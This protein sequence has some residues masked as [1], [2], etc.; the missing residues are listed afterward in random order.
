[1]S[2]AAM[3]TYITFLFCLFLGMT[4]LAN[5]PPY[6]NEEIM[7][8]TQNFEH[9]FSTLSKNYIEQS[10]YKNAL[11]RAVQLQEFCQI[12]R[13]ETTP[14]G[15]S[16][17]GLKDDA[18]F[19]FDILEL[20]D[21]WVGCVIQTNEEIQASID[22]IK[23]SSEHTLKEETITILKEMLQ[24]TS[25]FAKSVS[26]EKSDKENAMS[27]STLFALNNM[28]LSTYYRL[29][30][31]FGKHDLK[32][33]GLS[34]EEAITKL[35]KEAISQQEDAFLDNDL[36]SLQTKEFVNNAELKSEYALIIGSF[37]DCMRRNAM[38]PKL[39]C[40]SDLGSKFYKIYSRTKQGDSTLTT[41]PITAQDPH[42]LYAFRL[43]IDAI[44]FHLEACNRDYRNA[45]KQ[46]DMEANKHLQCFE[47]VARNSLNNIQEAKYIYGNN[48]A[49]SESALAYLSNHEYQTFFYNTG[50]MVAKAYAAT[51]IDE[52][53]KLVEDVYDFIGNEEKY[54]LTQKR[55]II[56]FNTHISSIPQEI[57]KC[58]EPLEKNETLGDIMQIHKIDPVCFDT[59][60]EKYLDDPFQ[61]KPA[62]WRIVNSDKSPLVVN[63]AQAALTYYAEQSS[64]PHFVLQ[65]LWLA[66]ACHKNSTSLFLDRRDT[67]FSTDKGI[68]FDGEDLSNHTLSFTI[69]GES[70]PLK[71]RR[72]SNLM[73]APSGNASISMI[74]KMFDKNLLEVTFKEANHPQGEVTMDFVIYGLEESIKS[75]RETCN[76]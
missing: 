51:D 1:M 18:T 34:L 26:A 73:V 8:K 31:L 38:E 5:T 40:F 3:R 71:M 53:A 7:E 52:K 55:D 41:E 70:F 76:W 45:K 12:K 25:S 23:I 61:F 74:K 62:T 39:E 66:I 29:I 47:Q 42:Q 15:Y 32:D 16:P 64:K 10:P 60:A 75:I 72:A 20:R 28:G 37:D 9:K 27:L 43:T 49:F 54:K 36:V 19:D 24:D 44:S 13:K 56:D 65:E 2:G 68:T 46:E 48:P 69:D 67:D 4:T 63:R 50:N 22:E 21:L 59:F 6:P 17:F 35:E 33:S 14:E 58:Q 11:L 57:E 30:Y